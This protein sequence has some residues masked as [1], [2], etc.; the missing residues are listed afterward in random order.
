MERLKKIAERNN[1]IEI[2]ST[3]ESYIS[4]YDGDKEKCDNIVKFFIEN[5][6]FIWEKDDGITTH[7]KFNTKKDEYIF[8]K[9]RLIENFT[10]ERYEKVIELYQECIKVKNNREEIKEPINKF[11]NK[12]YSSKKSEKIIITSKKKVNQNKKISTGVLV[13]VVAV[14]GTIIL[15]LKR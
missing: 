3:I 12:K 6:S 4:Y 5:S 8:E 14:V 9:M 1:R 10:K 11:S 13:S 2:K 7:K 15:L